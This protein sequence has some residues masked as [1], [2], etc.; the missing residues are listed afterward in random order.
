MNQER[1]T[2]LREAVLADLAVAKE[3]FE[4]ALLPDQPNAFTWLLASGPDYG[5]SGEM[6][7][8]A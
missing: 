4:R 1:I 5:N 2:K 8:A 3:G 6:K 7:R